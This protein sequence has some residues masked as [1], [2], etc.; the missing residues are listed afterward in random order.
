MAAKEVRSDDIEAFDDA[1]K[2][3]CCFF[4]VEAL[5][6][7]QINT[8]RAFVS[9]KNLY[10]S[11]PTGYGK[12]LVFQC[13]PLIRDVMKDELVGTLIALV[14]SPL[15]SLMTDQVAKLRQT[16]VTGDA[17]YAGQAVDVLERIKSG[18][19]SIIYASPESV[20]GT[21]YWRSIL[22]SSHFQEHCKILVINEA[23]CVVHWYELSFLR[24][25]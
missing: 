2:M 16:G 13:L 19:Y 21:D 8:I 11:T 15:K 17:I 14:I 22:S 7:D 18:D 20:L 3:T 9:G 1:I 6:P 25:Y 23:H 10:F 24:K 12:S 4:N 5:M